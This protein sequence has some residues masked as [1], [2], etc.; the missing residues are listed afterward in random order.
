MPQRFQPLLPAS[1]TKLLACEIPLY[2]DHSRNWIEELELNPKHN[3]NQHK[4]LLPGIFRNSVSV[5]SR[6]RAGH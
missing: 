1:E 4:L 6:M 5:G 2:I 3:D